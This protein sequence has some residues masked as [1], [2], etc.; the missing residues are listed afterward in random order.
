M[1]IMEFHFFHFYESSKMM[2]TASMLSVLKYH[3]DLLSLLSIAV[4][5]IYMIQALW[6]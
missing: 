4:S 6:Q 3:K 1:I 2:F 5:E